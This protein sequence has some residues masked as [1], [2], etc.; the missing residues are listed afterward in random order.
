[1]GKDEKL[2][3]ASFFQRLCAYAIDVVLVSLIASL[4]AMPFLDTVSISKLEDSMAET[5]EVYLSGEIDEATYLAESAAIS[6]QSGKKYGALTIITILIEILYF[7][8]YQVY[9][10]GQTLGKKL[11]K[12]KVE[13]TNDEEVSMNQM[14]YRTLIIDSI[15]YSFVNLAFVVFAGQN[16]Y[17][18]GMLVFELIQYAV[19]IICGLMVMFSKSGRGLHD[20]VSHTRVVR[21][22]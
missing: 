8:V 18:Y 5:A 7:I 3:K 4:V 6:Y 19:T 15:L 21:L 16:T 11:F 14:I 9:N 22:D 12:I 10:K 20:I 1:M 17:F 13:S 2:E